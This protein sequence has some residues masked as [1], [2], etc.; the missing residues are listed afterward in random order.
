[1]ENYN[2][3]SC[4]AEVFV[5]GCPCEWADSKHPFL[6]VFG[7]ADPEQVAAEE[8][9]RANGVP[10][11]Y[12]AKDG[13]RCHPGNAYQGNATIGGT[14]YQGQPPTWVLFECDVPTPAG[15]QVIRCDHHREGDPG[16]G[17]PAS[18]YWEASSLGQ[19]FQMLHGTLKQFKK[20][21]G[22]GLVEWRDELLMVAAADH[23]LNAAYRG[24]C[25]GVD[26]DAL[27]QWR[28]ESRAAFQKRSV[29]EVLADVEAAR[30]KLRDAIADQVARS[31]Y[32]QPSEYIGNGQI[33]W[34]NGSGYMEVS[35]CDF[36]GIIADLRGEHIHELPEASAREGIPFLASM[37]DRDGR[38]KVSI[39]GA[40]ERL[41]RKFLDGK[42]VSGLA[43]YYGDPARGFA[44]GY[45]PKECPVEPCG[46]C[47]Y[48]NYGQS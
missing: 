42:L 29:A 12:A 18:E 2:C 5:G 16:Y 48:C 9:C 44:G 20:P 28:A 40:G 26:P 34:D 41:V 23:C 45:F 47:E 38:K 30:K 22:R 24:Q 25:P 10:F 36:M 37:Q 19:L 14:D 27:M 21:Q 31:G 6:V 32:G 43:D 4:G 11:T 3:Q 46:N 13:K 8:L 1:M 35:D 7:P 39:M 33:R 17:R 15:V